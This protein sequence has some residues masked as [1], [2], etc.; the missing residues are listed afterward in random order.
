MKGIV[1]AIFITVKIVL[2]CAVLCMHAAIGS[3]TG[4]ATASVGKLRSTADA[5]FSKG[6][7]EEA[8]KIWAKVRPIRLVK[9]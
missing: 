2:V 6:D 4:T 9:S 3:E 7:L 1:R 5:A 8:L